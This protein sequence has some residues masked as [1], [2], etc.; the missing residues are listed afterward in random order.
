MLLAAFIVWEHHRESPLLDL[1]VIRNARSSAA[2]AT[3][4]VAFLALFG[5][6]FLITQYFQFV[7]GYSTLSAGL[8]TLPFA[9]AGALAASIAPRLVN[10]V[11]TAK[12]VAGGLALMA[13]GFLVA[14]TISA[15]SSYRS[16]GLGSGDVAWP[17]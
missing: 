10:R 13:S 2:S 8:H 4:T 5:F 16:V 7:R 12:V 9:V 15:S 1:G 11:G 17:R 14:A 6:I 3:E